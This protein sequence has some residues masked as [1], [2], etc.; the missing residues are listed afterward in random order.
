M[1]DIL[2]NHYLSRFQVLAIL[3][4]AY[5]IECAL[6][7]YTRKRWKGKQR[8]LEQELASREAQIDSLEQELTH[9]QEK[10]IS[11]EQELKEC[12]PRRVKELGKIV[13]SCIGHEVTGPLKN[14]RRW[15]FETL[16]ELDREQDDLRELQQKIGIMASRTV[17]RAINIQNLFMPDESWDPSKRVLVQMDS[18]IEDMLRDDF[19][20][21]EKIQG[22]TI[23]T[24]LAHVKPTWLNPD[25]TCV[26]IGN[27]VHNA[28]RYSKRGRVVQVILSLEESSRVETEKA[29]CVEVQD[30]GKGIAEEFHE[31]IFELWDV[32]DGPV[33]KGH[34]LGLG[35]ARKAA[36]L[37]GGDVI[38]VRSSL[39][40]GAVFQILLPYTGDRQIGGYDEV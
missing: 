7:W 32:G 13:E 16:E 22:V 15:S 25:L 35:L 2:F 1:Y 8:T 20:S 39:N 24:T 26:A 5:S 17:Q 9:R 36:R 38:L 33:K 27:V 28:I 11:L 12:D 23:V 3:L 40:Q 4:L 29:I 34:G 31:K 19:R 6:Y 37:Q 21:F 14:I 18:F 30:T 10:I